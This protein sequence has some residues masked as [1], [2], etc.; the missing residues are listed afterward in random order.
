[1][2]KKSPHSLGGDKTP[3]VSKDESCSKRLDAQAIAV[4]FSPL[5][6]LARNYAEPVHRWS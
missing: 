4:K 2:R 5:G 6:D 1:M 3:A